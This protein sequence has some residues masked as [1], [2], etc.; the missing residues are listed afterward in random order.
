MARELPR[1]QV[2][3]L[4]DN[5]TT[6]TRLP[7]ILSPWG[8]N[9]V[10]RVATP[11]VLKFTLQSPGAMSILIPNIAPGL[12]QQSEVKHHQMAATMSKSN[13]GSDN[14]G[15]NWEDLVSSLSR[16]YNEKVSQ[17]LRQ[18]EYNF[19]LSDPRLPDH[20]IVY[21]S[22]GFLKMSGY[23]QSEVLGR[24]CRFLQGPETDRRTVGEIRDAVREERPCQVRILNYRKDGKTFWNLFHM[25]PVFSK[26]DGRVIHFVGVQTPIASD[27]VA[28]PSLMND[29]THEAESLSAKVHEARDDQANSE[30]S[31]S[32]RGAR[33]SEEV[34]DQ[35]LQ[36]ADN[37]VNNVN[38][39]IRGGG[40]SP[41]LQPVCHVVL[42]FAET[43]VEDN[44][45]EISK[46][47]SHNCCCLRIYVL[48]P[49]FTNS[50]GFSW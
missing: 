16:S 29:L 3:P 43:N 26:T 38:L 20:P 23:E 50:Q 9:S 8:Y 4:S 6:C 32:E 10:I 34:A 46:V 19:V 41:L 36:T 33:E 7:V 42:V 49:S 13:S 25:A 17:A 22:E 11:E 2:T 35:G 24:N 1:K 45:V 15:R 14:K 30:Q 27:L 28:A 12:E 21:A 48:S 47:V 31:K 44:G 39:R 40:Q 18:H 37:D 5:F